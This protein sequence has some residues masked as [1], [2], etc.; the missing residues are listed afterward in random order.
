ML[1]I[2]W[3]LHGSPWIFM[4]EFKNFEYDFKLFLESFNLFESINSAFKFIVAQCKNL[5]LDP[6]TKNWSNSRIFMFQ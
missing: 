1:Q 2:K 5:N 3:I 6:E 4:L